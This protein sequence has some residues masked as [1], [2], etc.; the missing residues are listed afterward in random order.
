MVPRRFSAISCWGHRVH[1]IIGNKNRRRR[2]DLLSNHTSYRTDVGQRLRSG[3][4][5]HI[6][7]RLQ[8]PTLEQ[9][10]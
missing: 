6:R 8:S 7:T 4:Q 9:H 3:H 5:E 2:R 10:T 1:D